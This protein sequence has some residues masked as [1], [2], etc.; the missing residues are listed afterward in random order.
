M[1][2]QDVSTIDAAIEAA[3]QRKAARAASESNPESG[4]AVAKAT[5]KDE[6]SAE[7]KAALE[8]EKAAAKAKKDA[9]RAAKKLEKQAA[10]EAKKAERDEKRAAKK[11]AKEQER[12]AHKPHTSKLDKARAKLPELDATCKQFID[13]INGKKCDVEMYDMLT[14]T[15]LIALAQYLDFMARER[16]TTAA[17]DAKL[18]VGQTVRIT[19]SKDTRFIGKLGT[20]TKVQRIRCYV[21]VPGAK[22]PVYLFTSDVTALP[23]EE[24]TPEPGAGIEAAPA[25]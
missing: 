22:R 24:I 16:Q 7:E 6:P 9:D 19:S 14:S 2:I 10:R 17:L 4:K 11:T 18:E 8:R 12:G 25:E 20:L 5:K 15:Q 23:K 1:S 21:D 13:I 3:K